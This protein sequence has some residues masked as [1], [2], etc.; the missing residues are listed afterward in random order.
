MAIELFE[1]LNTIRTYPRLMKDKRTGDM[2]MTLH[3][4]VGGIV[5][6]SGAHAGKTLEGKSVCW[7][8]LED[9]PGS[10]T[11]WNKD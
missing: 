5:W 2:A 11:L 3:D 8:Y 1:D 6:L 10:V 7:E 4:H 9:H